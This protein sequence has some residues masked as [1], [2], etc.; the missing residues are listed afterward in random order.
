MLR[1][2]EP[3]VPDMV[4]LEQLT[5]AV[6]LD[7]QEDVDLYVRVMDRLGAKALTPAQTLSFLIRIR[8]QT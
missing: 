8:D 7:N 2:R 4:Y 1:F 6:Y 5:S 3:A